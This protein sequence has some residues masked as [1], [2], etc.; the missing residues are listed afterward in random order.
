MNKFSS[1]ILLFGGLNQFTFCAL[2]QILERQLILSGIVISAYGPPS[3]TTQSDSLDVRQPDAHRLIELCSQ[4]N[5]PVCYFIDQ[6]E[7]LSNFVRRHPADLFVL[8]CYPR[9]LE[10]SIVHLA[11]H[12][13]INIHPSLLPR[14][15]G[16]D[17][18][19]WQ[20]RRGETNTGVTLHQVAQQLDGGDILYSGK[21]PFEPGLRLQQI[22]SKLVKCGIEFLE[23]LLQTPR[24]EWRFQAQNHEEASWHPAPC[25]EDFSIATD[26]SATAAF[27]IVRAYADMNMPLKVVAADA[28]YQV[29]DVVEPGAEVERDTD[30]NLLDIEFSDGILRFVVD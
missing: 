2:S 17:P 24:C 27:N 10:D 5:V 6:H 12:E 26:F 9:R 7:Q 28:I 30:R 13:C 23:E 22:Q 8:A 14:Y 4:R 18:L 11:R 20:L 16:V 29:R 21:V 25:E 1:S 15:R 19:F 3:Q